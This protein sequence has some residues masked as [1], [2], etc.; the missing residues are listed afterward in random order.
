MY[1]T[2]KLSV[3]FCTFPHSV[4][5]G[6]KTTDF[7]VTA[8]SQC[9]ESYKSLM[10]QNEDYKF[11]VYSDFSLNSALGIAHGI[12]GME[13]R[14]PIDRILRF[15]DIDVFKA[16]ATVPDDAKFIKNAITGIDKDAEPLLS[17]PK[18]DELNTILKS[19]FVTPVIHRIIYEVE[20]ETKVQLCLEIFKNSRPRDN[21]LDFEI[22]IDSIMI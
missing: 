7:F 8:V 3:Q 22:A 5:K 17:H 15:T 9:Y 19:M 14:F 21:V 20:D 12:K 10:G 16:E 2:C 6:T 18:Y 4:Y 1:I 13:D 11:D